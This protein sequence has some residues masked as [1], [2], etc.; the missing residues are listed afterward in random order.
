MTTTVTSFNT[1][2]VTVRYSL[3]EIDAIKK[4]FSM[5]VET[6]TKAQRKFTGKM[7]SGNITPE[8]AEYF[9]LLKDE[10]VKVAADN[11]AGFEFIKTGHRLTNF[12][13]YLKKSGIEYSANILKELVFESHNTSEDYK[14]NPFRLVIYTTG[15]ATLTL[16]N[17]SSKKKVSYVDT[18][19]GAVTD[20]YY[21]RLYTDASGKTRRSFVIPKNYRRL[22]VQVAKEVEVVA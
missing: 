2:D 1:P 15:N 11:E 5:Y 19:T 9:S 16:V 12:Q 10:K 3:I 18:A 6:K 22:M 14:S 17:I 21:H 4:H 8:L 13:K 20:K 7:V